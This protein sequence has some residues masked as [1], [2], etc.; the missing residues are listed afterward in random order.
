MFRLKNIKQ[1]KNRKN[2]IIRRGTL[3]KKKGMKN[4]KEKGMDLSRAEKSPLR[5]FRSHLWNNRPFTRDAKRILR[6]Y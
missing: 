2:G 1:R 6:R 5:K 3:L 4:M